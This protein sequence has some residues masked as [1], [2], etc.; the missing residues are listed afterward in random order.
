VIVRAIN[1][2]TS[3]DSFFIILHTFSLQ[4]CLFFAY[5]EKPFI[6]LRIIS[7]ACCF[8]PE[9][10]EVGQIASKKLDVKA[11]PETKFLQFHS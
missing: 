10:N 5:F 11:I 9:K 6:A 2:R 7:Y 3:L 8:T 4:V 1:S